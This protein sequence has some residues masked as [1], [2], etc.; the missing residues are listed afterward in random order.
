MTIKKD[1]SDLSIKGESIQTLYGY[2]L[3]KQFLVNRRYQRKL[4]WSIEEKKSFINSIING[5]PV[6]LIL[7]A[8]VTIH[9]EKTLEIIDGMQR[10]NA[11]MSF[12]NQEFDIEGKYFDLDT[13]A[14]SKLLKDDGKLVQ[15][16]DILDRALCVEIARYQIPLSI[17][18]ESEEKNVDEIF[19]R[20]NSGGK[21]LSKQELR[22]AG[23]LT[24]F[25]ILVR[26]LSS[27]IRGDSSASQILDLN[28][29][30]NISITNKNLE[31]GI[32]IED[33]F[34]VRNNIISKEDLRQSKDEEI[35]ADILAWVI[36][37]K[38]IR[39]SYEILDELYGFNYDK[40]ESAIYQNVETNIKKIN[41]EVISSNIQFVF[42][43]LIELLKV[44]GKN[45]NNL[46]FESQQ[47]RISRYF[48]IVFYSLYE[49]LISQNK[50]IS[51][52]KALIAALDKAGDK[53]IKLSAG[54]GRWSAKEKQ[55]QTDAFVG[56]ISR[57][58]IDSDNNDPARSQWITKFENILMQSSTEQ[59]LYD[60]K[61]GLHNLDAAR[62]F[63]ND[64]FDKVICTLTAMANTH[65]NA[66][67]YCLIG[68]S[69]SPDTTRRYKEIYGTEAIRYSNFD[70]TGANGDAS[71]YKKLS[72][73]YFTKIVNLI[74]NQPIT[75]R[76]KDNLL[77]NISLIKYFEKEVILLK[78]ESDSK[79]SIYNGKYF[80]RHG[81]NLSEV[82][83]ENFADLFKRFQ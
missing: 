58:F 61:V 83:A 3:K 7:L 16:T 41:T 75:D 26:Q 50:Q 52:K 32:N 70:I 57:N 9:E 42:D 13:M 55:T 14:D 36:S 10:M 54:G 6:P 65:K 8:E 53:V 18:Q 48:Q 43:S 47:P 74:K 2:Y 21:H 17:Y 38:S 30:K 33:I 81:S 24:D 23:V 29:M 69:D 76:D 39:S 22:Q 51:D 28:S 64:L 35:I 82:P 63:N 34:W 25:A 15:K 20:L 62:E 19:R 31:Y 71:N 73:E 44:S 72:D 5:Y 11:I 1:S 49:L 59:T 66:V 4:V 67:G 78:I 40:E 68:V 56:V 60:F 80:V 77:R 27:N 37:D 46:I 12:I 79:P 45:F